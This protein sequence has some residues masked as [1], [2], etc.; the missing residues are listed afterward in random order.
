MVEKCRESYQKHSRNISTVSDVSMTFNEPLKREASE[1][2]CILLCDSETER[3]C[4]FEAFYKALVDG[5]SDIRGAQLYHHHWEQPHNDCQGHDCKFCIRPAGFSFG[6]G[7]DSGNTLSVPFGGNHEGYFRFSIDKAVFRLMLLSKDKQ[8]LLKITTYDFL[9]IGVQ[10]TD[11]RGKLD[12]HIWEYEWKRLERHS[13]KAVAPILLL[14]YFRDV[15]KLGHGDVSVDKVIDDSKENVR[16]SG[17]AH[18]VIPRFCDFVTGSSAQLCDIFLDVEKLYKHP[19]FVLQQCAYNNCLNHFA[20]II[21]NPNLTKDD[22]CYNDDVVG[23]NPIMIAAKLRHK[24]LVSSIL[25]SNKFQLTD[26]N[27]F[28]AELVHTRNAANQTLLAMV[29]LQGILFLKIFSSD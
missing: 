4:V 1:I 28:L 22:L 23:D 20:K 24:D 3:H 29:A 9:M 2:K 14:G 7:F 13:R 12:E 10:V 27:E 5:Q 25:R 6:N 8:N 15:L 16:K 17:K 18:Q 21:E 19:G 26:N 11:S